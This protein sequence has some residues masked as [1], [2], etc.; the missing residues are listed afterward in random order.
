[1]QLVRN[2]ESVHG[3]ANSEMGSYKSDRVDDKENKS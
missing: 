1:M 3:Q 2:I